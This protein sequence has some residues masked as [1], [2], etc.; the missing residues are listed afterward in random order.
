MILSAA[1]EALL[2][3]EADIAFYAEHG[4]FVTGTILPEALL[5]DAEYGARRYYAGERDARL[6]VRGGYLDWHVEDGDGLRLNDYA[7][8]Q[9]NELHALVTYPLL[10]AIAARL[11]GVKTLRL[12]HDQLITKG[13]GTPERETTVGW[14][15]DRAY[16]RTCSS[17]SMLTAWIPLQDT[18]EEMGPL[19][20]IDG[21]H[22][23][24]E[25]TRMPTFVDRDLAKLE[26]AHFL[27]AD[28][29]QVPMVLKRGQVSFHHG[30]T[31]HGSRDNRSGAERVA[32]TVHM[33]D[34]DNRYVPPLDARQRL[35]VH[36][37]DVLCR[38][39]P[40]GS[41]DYA[42]PAICPVLWTEP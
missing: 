42:D 36:M 38:R 24:P 37:N 3:S 32:L 29:R 15:T 14:H 9:N 26:S 1:E 4:W 30:C 23:W 2:P 34:G 28:A 27:R 35:S 8:L 5:E 33:Q 19:T 31:V 17:Q 25:P 16:W 20:V 22:K 21:S 7:S 6:S 41:P 39:G 40:D 11:A 10:G 18:T 12:F 13:S